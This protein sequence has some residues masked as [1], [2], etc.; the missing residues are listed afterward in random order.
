MTSVEQI[1]YAGLTTDAGVAAVLGGLFWETLPQDAFDAA[2]N[3]PGVGITA[4]AV[5]SRTST[6]QYVANASANDSGWCRISITI[7]DY[8]SNSLA[9]I[10]QAI[11][12][13]FKGFSAAQYLSPP[14]PVSPNIFVDYRTSTEPQSNPPLARADLEYMVFY[15]G[16]Q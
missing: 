6:K 14:Q 1:V 16:T 3:P 8:D 11:V 5:F 7:W 10:K 2:V 15:Q 4:R 9:A 12:N 13:A